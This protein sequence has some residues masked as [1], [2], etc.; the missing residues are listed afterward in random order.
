MLFPLL[1]SPIARRPPPNLKI[2]VRHQDKQERQAASY[3]AADHGKQFPKVNKYSHSNPHMLFTAAN[4]AAPGHAC[5]GL[6]ITPEG[7]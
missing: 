2:G 5:A 4:S 7:A 6:A 1:P 3:H